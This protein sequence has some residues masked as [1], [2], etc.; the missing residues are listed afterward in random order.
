MNTCKALNEN[1][2]ACHLKAGDRQGLCMTH[3]ARLEKQ[4]VRIA[5]PLIP[6]DPQSY[7][8]CTNYQEHCSFCGQGTTPAY[9]QPFGWVS[10]CSLSCFL[11][12]TV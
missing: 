7:S 11:E 4:P 2:T 5:P 12:R 6:E 3:M 1:G 8:D 9:I 10:V